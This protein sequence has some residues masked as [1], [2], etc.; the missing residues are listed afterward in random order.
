MRIEP[1]RPVLHEGM[2]ARAQALDQEAR[3]H[4]REAQRHRQA[5]Q[6]AR[7]KLKTLQEAC[8]RLGIAITFDPS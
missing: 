6:I 1:E 2:A 5:A 8:E 7:Q 3:H 4:K